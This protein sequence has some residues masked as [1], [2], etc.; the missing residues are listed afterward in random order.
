[1]ST[2]K[3]RVWI[4]GSMGRREKSEHASCMRVFLKLTKS[5]LIGILSILKFQ[6]CLMDENHLKHKNEQPPSVP[7]TINTDLFN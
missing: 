5:F 4:N 2:R 3:I 1:M 7:S 6:A